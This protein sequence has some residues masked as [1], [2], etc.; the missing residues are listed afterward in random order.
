MNWEAIGA[1]GE[2]IGAIATI[3]TLMYLAV[4]IRGN[5][6]LLRSQNLHAATSQMHQLLDVQRDPA[7]SRVL[8]KSMNQEALSREDQ[9]VLESYVMTA[10]S[11]YSN[12]FEHY[13]EGLSTR[14]WTIVQ[15]GIGDFFTNFPWARLWWEEYGRYRFEADFVEQVDSAIEQ[16]FGDGEYLSRI[17]E[18]G[19]D[20]A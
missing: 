20:D 17:E 9:A 8:A 5:S 12:Q 10:L 2:T 7:V 18:R 6:R 19:N 16:S 4:Q 13:K 15:R 11:Y 3:G 14:S 1:I